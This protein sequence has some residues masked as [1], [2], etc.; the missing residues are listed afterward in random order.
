ME[1]GKTTPDLE[2]VVYELICYFKKWGMWEDTSIHCDGKA[3]T[4]VELADLLREDEN[5]IFYR[6]EKNRLSRPGRHSCLP[7]REQWHAH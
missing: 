1:A 7:W 5:S 6:C 3:Y 4:D 2:Q